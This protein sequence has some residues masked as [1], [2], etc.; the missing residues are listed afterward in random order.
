MPVKFK[1]K[2]NKKRGTKSC[3][4]GMKKKH[5]GGGS[6][7]G[8]GKAGYGK[9]KFTHM[10]IHEPDHLG[11][12]GFYSRRRNQLKVVNVS[13]L[14]NMADKDRVVFTGKILGSGQISKALTVVCAQIS[15]RA[16]D[17]IKKA[18]GKVEAGSDE[19]KPSKT[20]E[21]GVTNKEKPKKEA[22]PKPASSDI[23]ASEASKEK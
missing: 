22:V 8:R 15:A 2:I 5:R 3:G 1:R 4:H 21:V 19:E 6:R 12:K 18:G 10:L 9:H 20:N 17:K 13:Q 11:K 16:R 14:E 23:T 7:G